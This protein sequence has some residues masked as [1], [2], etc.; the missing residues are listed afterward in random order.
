MRT[1]DEFTFEMKL[2]KPFFG[3]I[4][5]LASY[6]CC[7]QSSGKAIQTMTVEEISENPVGT[8][9]FKFAEWKRGQKLVLE[10]FE[11]YWGENALIDQLIIVPVIDEASRVAAL[12]SGEIDIAE[13]LTPDNLILVRGVEGFEGYSRGAGAIYGL[14]PNHRE[15]PFDDQR[16]RRALSLC[17][18][19]EKLANQLMKGIHGPGAQIWGPAHEGFDPD[20]PQITD[21]YDPEL[22]KEL[23]AEAGYPDGFETKMFSSTSGQGVPELVVNSFIVISLRE[24][25]IELELVNL[26]WMTYIGY[27]LGGIPEGENTGLFTMGMGT[28]DVA[29]FDQY[30]HSSSWPPS[31]WSVGYYANSDVD[32]LIEKAWNATT[33]AEYIAA[34]RE[35]HQLALEDYA[36]IP[37][38]AM[39]LT[40]GV[41]DRV[42][43]WTAS[44]SPVSRFNKAFLEYER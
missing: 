36:Y 38:L 17:F 7:S 24:C 13:W 44:T 42:G 30:L 19:R 26:E 14:D 39:F 18:D 34:E 37:V 9:H 22:A 35:A 16:V 21:L 2:N 32:A 25:G 4:D 20:G 41:S 27:W 15:P 28:G 1:V 6:P 23:L 5:K 40:F 11:D 31:G 8:A 33:H 12:L 3:F 43:G 10:R 29:G